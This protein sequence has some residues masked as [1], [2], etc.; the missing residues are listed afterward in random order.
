MQQHIITSRHAV[1][2]GRCT[3]AILPSTQH[4]H[5]L[6]YVPTYLPTAPRHHLLRTATHRHHLRTAPRLHLDMAS[7][8]RRRRTGAHHRGRRMLVLGHPEHHH[9]HRH[10]YRTRTTPAGAAAESNP[11]SQSPAIVFFFFCSGCRPRMY[12]I[13]AQNKLIS[14]RPYV[15][16]H[17]SSRSS[18]PGLQSKAGSSSSSP[19][20]LLL[21]LLL[22]YGSCLGRHFFSREVFGPFFPLRL[23]AELCL[24]YVPTLRLNI[25]TRPHQ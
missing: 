4:I 21:L 6:T 10:R 11:G 25:G 23:L 13:Q 19:P 22:Q 5:H 3:T 15:L 7:H 12:R 9:D 1:Y 16:S 8:R 24:C 14:L 20:L 18:D 17:F 2:L